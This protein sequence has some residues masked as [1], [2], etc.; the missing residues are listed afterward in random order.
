M[1]MENAARKFDTSKS[2][3]AQIVSGPEKTAEN[4]KSP[5]EIWSGKYWDKIKTE[6]P[7]PK[8]AEAVKRDTERII[9][10]QLE[11][12]AK[13]GKLEL[14]VLDKN[15]TDLD[16]EKIFAY[17]EFAKR[18]KKY[19]V[20]SFKLDESGTK[21]SAE[22]SKERGKVI[23]FLKYKEKISDLFNKEEKGI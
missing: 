9:A 12:A 17:S 19:K 11:E 16:R 13:S 3:D 6:N 5:E 2:E 21:V 15:F 4:P 14:S 8:N 22:I 1:A 23:D 20:G 7:D 18:D 10:K